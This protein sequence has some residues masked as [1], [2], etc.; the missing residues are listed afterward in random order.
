MKMEIDTLKTEIA[1]KKK[2]YSQKNENVIKIYGMKKDYEEGRNN[3]VQ[4]GILE[5][6]TTHK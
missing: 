6:M 1:N 5:T 2:A 4:K 3:T